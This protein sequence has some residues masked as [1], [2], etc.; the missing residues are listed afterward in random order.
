MPQ[1]AKKM[2]VSRKLIARYLKSLKEK[3]IVERVGTQEADIGK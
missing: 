2:T 1:M 3:G